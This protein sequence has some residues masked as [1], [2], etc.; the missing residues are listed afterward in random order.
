MEKLQKVYDIFVRDGH[1][2]D[3][4]KTPFDKWAA[5]FSDKPERQ[6]ELY[7]FLAEKKYVKQKPK[8]VWLGEAFGG[9]TPEKK[10]PEAV[11]SSPV[12]GVAAKTASNG[13]LEPITVDG[14]SPPFVSTPEIQAQKGAVNI[15]ANG[16]PLEPTIAETAIPTEMRAGS[17]VLSTSEQAKKEQEIQRQLPMELADVVKAQ[18]G[19]AEAAQRNRQ[20]ER[21]KNPGR[22]YGLSEQEKLGL[23]KREDDQANA[24][25]A[26]KKSNPQPLTTKMLDMY[27]AKTK[28]VK[29]PTIGGVLN[30]TD[31]TNRDERALQGLSSQLIGT[32]LGAELETRLQKIYKNTN[33]KDNDSVENAALDAKKAFFDLVG[34]KDTEIWD[35][36][37]KSESNYNE[38][39]ASGFHSRLNNQIKSTYANAGITEK[40]AY[41]QLRM[42]SLDRGVMDESRTQEAKLVEQLDQQGEFLDLALESGDQS[43]IEKTKGNYNRT[44]NE[45]DQMRSSRLAGVDDEIAKLQRMLVSP[46][47]T[48]EQKAQFKTGLDKLNGIKQGFINPKA[49]A[50]AKYALYEGQAKAA[51]PKGTPMQQLRKLYSEL[52]YQRGVLMSRITKAEGEGGSARFAANE[53]INSIGGGGHNDDHKRLIEIDAQLKDLAPIVYLNESPEVKAHETTFWEDVKNI[54]GKVA[55]FTGGIPL[56]IGLATGAIQGG[57]ET[58]SGFGSTAWS[59]LLNTMGGKGSPLSSTSKQEDA[60]ALMQNLQVGGVSAEML[61]DPTMGFLKERAKEPGLFDRS[62]VGNLFGTSGGL[63]FHLLLAAEG[64]KGLGLASALSSLTK[65]A[66]L[67]KKGTTVLAL[68]GDAI[69]SGI[70]YKTAGTFSVDN[71]EELTFAGGFLGG[72]AG[73]LGKMGVNKA[74]KVIAKVF[75]DKATEAVKTIASW[76]ARRAGAGVG[77]SFEE[78]G[79]QIV[80]LWNQSDTGEAFWEKI[81]KQFGN[82]SEVV[83]FYVSTFMMGAI[84]GPAN[85]DGLGAHLS[86]YAEQQ[87]ASMT[88]KDRREAGAIT[89]QVQAEQQALVE[90]AQGGEEAQGGTMELTPEAQAAQAE[91]ERLRKT[92]EA[93][94]GSGEISQA[95]SEGKSEADYVESLTQED[96]KQL[97]NRLKRTDL[98]DKER[99]NAENDLQQRKAALEGFQQMRDNKAFVEVQQ[100]PTTTEE[101]TT[102]PEVGVY[103]AETQVTNSGATVET[104][105]NGEVVATTT[106]DDDIPIEI[107]MDMSRISEMGRRTIEAMDAENTV[108]APVTELN[109]TPGTPEEIAAL[110][111][112]KAEAG[113]TPEAPPISGKETV[114]EQ[115]NSRRQEVEGEIQSL[116]DE[117]ES[118]KKKERSLEDQMAKELGVLYKDGGNLSVPDAEKRIVDSYDRRIEEAKKRRKEATKELEAKTV[119]RDNLPQEEPVAQPAP[120]Q[121]SGKEKPL[122][123]EKKASDVPAAEE[124]KTRGPRKK[125]TAN[126]KEAIDA[127]VEANLNPA[128]ETKNKAEEASDRVAESFTAELD[129]D[130]LDAEI[131]AEPSTEKTKEPAP[132]KKAKQS[133]KEELPDG[134]E[135]RFV[136]VTSEGKRTAWE[137]RGGKWYW[138]NYK[139]MK[140]GQQT[141]EFIQNEW[142]EAKGKDIDKAEKLA[143]MDALKRDVYNSA[144]SWLAAWGNLITVSGG[145]GQA[146]AVD[147]NAGESKRKAT[148]DAWR[149]VATETFNVGLA[150]AR[151]LAAKGKYTYATWKDKMLGGMGEHMSPWIDM[152]WEQLSK[153]FPEG[154]TTPDV[155]SN[156]AESPAPKKKSKKKKKKKS[157]QGG[158][159]DQRTEREKTGVEPVAGNRGLYETLA[160]YKVPQAIGRAMDAIDKTYEVTNLKG[161]FDTALKEVNKLGG[162]VN[163]EVYASLLSFP[164]KE[165]GTPDLQAMPGHQAKRLMAIMFYGEM[166]DQLQQMKDAAKPGDD[167][168]DLNASITETIK[169]IDAISQVTAESGTL[170]GV[171]NAASSEWRFM[172]ANTAGYARAQINKYNATLLETP[173]G[174]EI[175]EKSKNTKERLDEIKDNAVDGI[176]SATTVDNSISDVEQGK[177]LPK[178]KSAPQKKALGMTRDQI[179]EMKAKAAADMKIAAKQGM[180]GSLGTTA[181]FDFAD[182]LGRYGVAVM[183]EGIVTFKEWKAKMKSDLPNVTNE[184]LQEAWDTHEHDGKTL[185]EIS[186]EELAKAAAEPVKRTE[187]KKKTLRGK[188][189]GAIN[190]HFKSTKGMSKEEK[191]KRAANPMTLEERLMEEAGLTQDEAAHVADAVKTEFTRRTQ[192]QVEATA[193]ALQNAIQRRLN[194]LKRKPKKTGPH[195]TKSDAQKAI[196][197]MVDGDFTDAMVQEVFAD[198]LG[199]AQQL[200][201][202]DMQRARELGKTLMLTKLGTDLHKKAAME[203][204]RFMNS[205]LPYDKLMFYG[206]FFKAIVYAQT[207]K[208]FTTHFKNIFSAASM[209]PSMFVET[210]I[211]VSKWKRAFRDGMEKAAKGG[212]KFDWKAFLQSSPIT[213]FSVKMGAL[214]RGWA[215]GAELAW[216]IMKTGYIDS[217]Y[218]DTGKSKLGRMAGI[219]ERHKFGK[220][221]PI[222]TLKYVGRALAAED[223]WMYTMN[224]EMELADAFR[225]HTLKHGTSTEGMTLSKYVKRQMSISDPVYAS[226]LQDAEADVAKV[227]K[228]LELTDRQIKSAVSLRMKEIITEKLG[229]SESETMEAEDIARSRIFTHKR[230]GMWGK[231]A[232]MMKA[233]NRTKGVGKVSWMWLMFAD[234]VGNFGDTVTD[235]VPIYGLLRA[236]GISPTG[237]VK[238]QSAN[239]RGSAAMGGELN[240]S[241][242]ERM[243]ATMGGRNDQRYYEQMGRAWLGTAMMAMAFLFAGDDD[244]DRDNWFHLSGKEDKAYPDF[245]Y[246]FG[247]PIM[248]WKLVPS[249]APTAAILTEAW[250]FRKS[251]PS[252][253]RGLADRVMYSMFSVEQSIGSM[254]VA[255]SVQNFTNAITTGMGMFV[256]AKRSGQSSDPVEVAKN[257]L[258]EIA[259]TGVNAVSKINPLTDPLVNQVYQLFNQEKFPHGSLEQAMDYAVLGV[260]YNTQSVDAAGNP[261]IAGVDIFGEKIVKIPG[262]ESFGYAQWFKD[263]K[264]N[265]S[266]WKFLADHGVLDVI[267]NPMNTT[268]LFE[269]EDAEFKVSRDKMNDFQFVTYAT[270]RGQEFSKK[271]EDYMKDTKKVKADYLMVHPTT[272]GNMSELQYHVKSLLSKA[273]TKAKKDMD[274]LPVFKGG[275]GGKRL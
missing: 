170:M 258:K 40:D 255:E 31:G 16:T 129:T 253:K 272:S 142:Q 22:Y 202:E 227:A 33:L 208:G 216:D 110:K 92:R 257:F 218:I 89:E 197:A 131:A 135:Q 194:A 178:K 220:W 153:V 206:E 158:T 162:F 237:I 251:H 182:A 117:I 192:K 159:T 55:S 239:S 213:E 238:R 254:S 214:A 111:E 25:I 9:L 7:D 167:V 112:K 137:K 39:N 62:Y 35:D 88:P 5:S 34:D 84:M 183:A 45:I 48:D 86:E 173:K 185:D 144:K 172:M 17:G 215:K 18:Q 259:V 49:I 196:D 108:E 47:F 87:L 138:R 267:S 114:V 21:D 136:E 201:P 14:I 96:V 230:E 186:K 140:K 247:K 46:S 123:P 13:T 26:D 3:P 246:M 109:T 113:K 81:G 36:Y 263:D 120:D 207:L 51:M 115:K 228:T 122:E 148:H 64:T 274:K 252:E 211:N 29:V 2:S 116:S 19:D 99:Q 100:K 10:K 126:T 83:K 217:K 97:E 245:I 79:Q 73:G 271:L 15:N 93:V 221:N 91:M 200:S 105:P 24:L 199:L 168:T 37:A 67:G 38:Y 76:G 152:A 268:M 157:K 244:D 4:A 175:K 61:S 132:E 104:K 210:A 20:R 69:E 250:E 176:D 101:N 60:M 166:A 72:I 70:N 98:T 240:G 75:G 235:Y 119:E 198:R 50:E 160:R 232:N 127:G 128:P 121:K 233:V 58:K 12:S 32:P 164:V 188:I 256:Q 264:M 191:A 226:A 44:R 94:S 275:F 190:N 234:I 85:S 53:M 146:F 248:S 224:H 180:A 169:R 231:L 156:V 273:G 165:D 265:D 82:V 77:E 23:W 249:I 118:L 219:L 163:P 6:G 266:R 107:T 262:E 71:A 151:V 171:A 181:V 184:Q 141:A 222:Q 133:K 269:D 150:V 193:D 195:N 102:I 260:F 134:V 223:A 43:R 56:A 68:L 179:A 11:V 90:S 177:P 41:Q 59:G 155:T 52:E 242:T 189:R 106:V 154:A 63:M 261:R 95:D 143:G 30:L 229:L 204:D 174:K 125:A 147:P 212:E 187:E 270:L 28:A 205:V 241:L 203:L 8:D 42:A 74:S 130:A 57:E 1:I 236:N 161:L 124:S 80:Q 66:N 54:G 145:S 225:R 78:T 103:P 243:Y 139:P 65:A 149:E 209:I 27:A